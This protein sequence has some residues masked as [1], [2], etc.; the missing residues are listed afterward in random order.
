MI[1]FKMLLPSKYSLLILS[2]PLNARF[3]NFIQHGIPGYHSTPLTK[4]THILIIQQKQKLAYTF[5]LC[6]TSSVHNLY[7]END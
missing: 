7:F 3:I 5:S 6:D 2:R 4:N 1:T